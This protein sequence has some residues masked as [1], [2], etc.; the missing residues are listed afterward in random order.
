MP[1]RFGY[2][3]KVNYDT[4]NS[5]TWTVLPNGGKIWQLN[6]ICPDA[7]SVNFC[8]D[9]FWIPEGGK[10]FIYSKDKKYSIGAFTS[11]NNKGDSAN[12]R[13]FATGLVFGNDIILEYYQPKEVSANAIISIDY[14]VHGYRYIRFDEKSSNEE[15]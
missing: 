2:R 11:K 10:F 9:K 6:V 3:H 1:P 8:Y 13:G 15:M 5:G 7:L 14:I 12:V 4:T